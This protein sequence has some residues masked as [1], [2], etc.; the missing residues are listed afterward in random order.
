M[1]YY[2]P[3][4]HA[5]NPLYMFILGF[6]FWLLKSKWFWDTVS[7]INLL[8][9]LLSLLLFFIWLVRK[10]FLRLRVA[11]KTGK[12]LC[13]FML[14]VLWY[15]KG[16]CAPVGSASVQ[17]LVLSTNWSSQAALWLVAPLSA[18]IKVGDRPWEVSQ[19]LICSGYLTVLADVWSLSATEIKCKLFFKS[20]CQEWSR[21]FF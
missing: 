6:C 13:K 7:S 10:A 11:D 18:V 19:P 12:L 5:L 3:L 14:E 20:D 8:V 21:C 16:N 4:P 17:N 9:L 1:W 15:Y 2:I